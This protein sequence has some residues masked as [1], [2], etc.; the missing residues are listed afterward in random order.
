MIADIL[1]KFSE[2]DIKASF[3]LSFFAAIIYYFAFFDNTKFDSQITQLKSNIQKEEAE[4]QRIQNLLKKEKEL[5]S[6]IGI[7]GKKFEEAIKYLP[8]NLNISAIMSNVDNISKLTSVKVLK[9]DTLPREIISFYEKIAL[10]VELQGY[11]TELVYFIYEMSKIPRIIRIDNFEIITQNSNT[12]N[13]IVNKKRGKSVG[14][15]K[16]TLKGSIISYRYVGF[17]DKNKDGNNN[18][19]D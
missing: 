8:T 2:M 12:N 6:E 4:W 19:N 15:P 17:K 10:D 5:K 7:L 14:S 16:L 3:I 13:P 11:Y 9:V 1:L 18:I